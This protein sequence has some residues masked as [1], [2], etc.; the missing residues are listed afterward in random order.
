M[1]PENKVF[2]AYFELRVNKLYYNQIKD[3]S[4][5]SHSSLQNTLLKLTKSR[6]LIEEKT[7]GNKFYS[8][9]NKKLVSI[10]FSEL[11]IQKFEDLNLG[12]KSPLGNFTKNLP[13]DIYTI[14]LF[15]S[16]AR[17]EETKHSDIDLLV[18]SNRTWDL[19][20]NKKE[21][22]LVSKYQLS[23]FQAT[24]EEFVDAKD[25]VIIQAKKTGFA[26]HKE[27]NF[28]EEILNEY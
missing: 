27:Q 11:A 28:Y 22:E 8:I 19:S 16:S 17:K 15:G 20:S 25:D 5:L 4:G 21:A 18:V 14:V 1:K 9:R 12:V 10:K 24:I 7:K 26:I 23:V 3:F 13:K 2:Q 6:M